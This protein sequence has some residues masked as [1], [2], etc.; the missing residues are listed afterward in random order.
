M[1]DPTIHHHRSVSK[2]LIAGIA[3]CVVVSGAANVMCG[4]HHAPF[5]T[6]MHVAIKDFK[7]YGSVPRSTRRNQTSISTSTGRTKAKKESALKDIAGG[8]REDDK[9]GEPKQNANRNGG[10]ITK[11]GG[12]D[13]DRVGGDDLQGDDD[14]VGASLGEDR[15]RDS[16]D[17]HKRGQMKEAEEGNDQGGQPKKKVEDVGYL[18]AGK[19][20]GDGNDA[21]MGKAG[22][23]E[24][25]AAREGEAGDDSRGNTSR[26]NEGEQGGQQK[27]ADAN[28][29]VANHK[30]GAQGVK[31]DDENKI[32]D[33]ERKDWNA[34][35]KD[36]AKLDEN[37]E[38]V[39]GGGEGAED[40]GEGEHDDDDDSI[41][42]GTEE[43]EAN[44]AKHSDARPAYLNC[45]AHGGPT[46]EFAQE[47]VYWYSIPSDAKVRRGYYSSKL[48]PDAKAENRLHTQIV[49]RTYRWFSFLFDPSM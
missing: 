30:G 40:G 42:D 13:D 23:T 41:P 48:Q 2:T 9:D 28:G 46:N 7:N 26:T 19:S 21:K 10:G 8:R 35:E 4:H 45:T 3:A 37:V 49:R 14:G 47:M 1:Q 38:N 33:Q 11:E 44:R 39:G 31:G 17:E 18:T 24:H 22:G 12:V 29:A 32:I 6:A 27:Q 34:V 25:D 5:E 20:E 43:E 36:A 16:G 15:S